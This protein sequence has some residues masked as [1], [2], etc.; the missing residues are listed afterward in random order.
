MSSADSEHLSHQTYEVLARVRL[1]SP[2]A[3]L[4]RGMLRATVPTIVFDPFFDDLCRADSITG[5]ARLP[6]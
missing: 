2:D 1:L 5:D 4:L 6:R 3:C